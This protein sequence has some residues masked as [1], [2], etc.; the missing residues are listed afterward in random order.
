MSERTPYNG[1]TSNIPEIIDPGITIPIYEED[2][3]DETTFRDQPDKL[4]SYRVR[5]GRRI[6]NKFSNFLPSIS[7]KLHH[8]KKSSSQEKVN[9]NDDSNSTIINAETFRDQIILQNNTANPY[10]SAHPDY[11]MP[12]NYLLE[13]I[14]NYSVPKQPITRSRNNTI[15]SQITMESSILQPFNATQNTYNLWTPNIEQSNF[16]PYNQTQSVVPLESTTTAHS[17]Y[18]TPVRFS[19]NH[20]VILDSAGSKNIWSP[21]I[22]S[23]RK[24]HSV[25]SPLKSDALL[26]QQK[27]FSNEYPIMH[28]DVDANTIN[29]VTTSKMA[30]PINQVPT[31]LPTNTV[32]ISN[33]F[34][35]QQFHPKLANVINLTSSALTLLCSKY[36]NVV[37]VRTLKGL[38]MALV[39]FQSVD[40][41]IHALEVLQNKSISVVGIPSAISFARILSFENT[42]MNNISNLFNVDSSVPH[43]LLQEQLYNGSISFQS[44]GNIQVPIFKDQLEVHAVDF[45]H[46]NMTTQITLPVEPEKCPFDLP[47]PSVKTIRHDLKKTVKAFD[48]PFDKS[49]IKYMIHNAVQCRKIHVDLANFGPTPEPILN[50]EFQTPKLREIRKMLDANTLSQFEIEQLAMCMLDELPELSFDYLG[51]TIVQKI[52]DKSSD[53]IRDIILRKISP[54]L[55]SLGIHK[56]GTWVCQKVIKLAHNPRSVNLIVEGIKQY[57]TPLFNDQFG[58]YVIQKVLKLGVPWNNFIFESI[59]VNFW[60]ISSNRYGSRAVRACLESDIITT[61][62]TLILSSMIALYAKYLITDSNGTL[63]ITWLLDT[64]DYPQK[65]ISLTNSIVELSTLAHLCCHK[66][67]SLTILKLFSTRANEDCKKLI[68]NALLDESEIYLDGNTSKKN[69]LEY[70]LND[71]SYGCTFI[72]K[73]L[74]SRVL[75]DETKNKV[76]ERTRHILLSNKS[77][78]HYRLMDEVGLVT[79]STQERSSKQHHKMRTV[80][81]KDTRSVRGMSLSS[82]RSN[83][84]QPLTPVTPIINGNYD[85]DNFNT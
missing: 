69:I 43:S 52:Y 19:D 27:P 56:S 22:T 12:A 57:C 75:E 72:Y 66:L 44:Q 31:L 7:A 1:T 84:V 76:M 46:E 65:Y 8:S 10:Q 83:N 6:S 49:R 64:C 67:G 5:A 11:E 32:A 74:S 17:D 39:E 70:I 37:S 78:Q 73:L 41:A 29:W 80:N 30:P 2:I 47:P 24:S 34:P 25:T 38:N 28:D 15:S 81:S 53:I 55:T 23:R 21:D 16:D 54:F 62:Q 51:N 14:E 3:A 50:R 82:V 33:I 60:V 9:D 68:V 48:V 13:S 20:S 71:N 85:Y 4:G 42:E 18:Q 63:L 61:E 45:K 77:I 40:G 59:I 36:G 58:N 35:L 79:I 26:N